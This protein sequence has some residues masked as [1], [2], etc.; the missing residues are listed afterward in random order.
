MYSQNHILYKV[1]NHPEDDVTAKDYVKLL[2]CKAEYTSYGSPD[3][4]GAVTYAIAKQGSTTNF[5]KY[6]LPV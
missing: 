4:F 3:A 5:Y 1:H 6:I 2:L